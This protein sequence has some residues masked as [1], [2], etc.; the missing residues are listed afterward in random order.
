MRPRLAVQDSALR[1]GNFSLRISPVRSGDAGLYEARVV[2]NAEALSCRV[3]LEVVTVTLSQ[4]SPVVENEPL[5]LSCSSS[6]RASLEETCWFHNRHLLP[7][8]R[9]FCFLRGAHFMLRPAMSDAGYWRCQLRYS[10]NEIIS[11]T[12]YLRILGNGPS[13]SIVYAAAGS[14]AD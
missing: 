10:D 6:H 4:P 12:Y 8:S 14:A 9:T 13:N 2:Y 1:G 11:A 3:Q 5:L 7:T